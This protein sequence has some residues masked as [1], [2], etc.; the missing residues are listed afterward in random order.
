MINPRRDAENQ[1]KMEFPI[2]IGDEYESSPTENQHK[3][4]LDVWTNGQ[5][6]SGDVD[7]Q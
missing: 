3:A 4:V 6:D 2:S 1:R 5:H 7:N